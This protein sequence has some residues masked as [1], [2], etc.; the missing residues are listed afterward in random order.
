MLTAS[1]MSNGSLKYSVLL[2]P[3]WRYVPLEKNV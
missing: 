3:S 1:W 2:L